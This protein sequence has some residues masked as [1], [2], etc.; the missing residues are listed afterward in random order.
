MTFHRYYI[1]PILLAAPRNFDTLRGDVGWQAWSEYITRHS[2]KSSWNN[3]VIIGW[4]EARNEGNSSYRMATDTHKYVT[5]HSK[6]YGLNL[7]LL[8]EIVGVRIDQSI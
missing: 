8:W 7:K 4:F 2:A 5:L 6:Q 1:G 3:R